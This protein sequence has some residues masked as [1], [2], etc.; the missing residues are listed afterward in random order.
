MFTVNRV[1]QIKFNNSTW[2]V[3]RAGRTAVFCGLSGRGFY[4]DIKDRVA[5]VFRLLD[6][7]RIIV[8]VPTPHLRLVKMRLKDLEIAEICRFNYD[9]LEL[10]ECELRLS[11]GSGL[12]GA[13]DRV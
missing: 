6:V 13:A 8:E 10:T 12:P 5:E 7:D 3:L 2:W 11:T 1:Q 9:D 4:N